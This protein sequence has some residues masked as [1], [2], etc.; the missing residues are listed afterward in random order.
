MYMKL[1]PFLRH[2]SQQCQTVS[3][4]VNSVNSAN[5]VNSYSAVLPPSPMVF[6]TFSNDQLWKS[7]KPGSVM[8]S[9]RGSA[10]I[11]SLSGERVQEEEYLARFVKVHHLHQPK[12]PFQLENQF[13]EA[14][15]YKMIIRP[16]A[17]P[18]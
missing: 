12:I 4:S 6:F 10:G 9:K 14:C 11:E 16:K 1:L 17:C 8:G 7:W 13:S 18:R 2:V 5:S 3:N 15:F